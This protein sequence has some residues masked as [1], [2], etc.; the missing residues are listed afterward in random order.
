MPSTGGHRGGHSFSFS[1]QTQAALRVP[2]FAVLAGII[3]LPGRA[4]AA[5]AAD[6][7]GGGAPLNYLQS[8][9]A[10][11]HEIV[12]LTWGVTWLSVAVVVIITALV[13]VGIVLR[14]RRVGD[15]RTDACP[16]ARAR[17]G[18]ALSW[19]Y[20]GII[21][22]V[23]ILAFFVTWTV[24]TMAEIRTPGEAPA[25]TIE[26]I[27]HQFWWEVIYKDED[28]STMFETA[29]EIRIPVGLPVR[30]VLRSADVIHSFWV[31]LLGGKTDMIPGRTNV[32]WLR[33]DTPG[34][35]R[36]QCVEYCGQ[37]HAHM[38]FR[39]VAVPKGEYDAW[40]ARQQQSGAEAAAASSEGD[41]S[42]R[43]AAP[44]MTGL[45]AEGSR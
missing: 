25:Q 14:A 8:Y 22:T 34:V 10:P 4:H 45:P 26:V 38:A 19:V 37:Q 43:A 36:G 40:L 16:V 15:M 30:F 31:P 17:E 35:Y 7:Q 41:T 18:R 28:G 6:P 3:A 20:G 27:G 13:A 9:G 24:A 42:S 11:G 1:W 12:G 33:A 44:A 23:A 2:G 29:N 21:T 39:L 5:G 32:A